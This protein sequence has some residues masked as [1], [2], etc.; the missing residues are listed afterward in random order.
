MIVMREFENNN[1][2]MMI[3]GKSTVEIA[4]EFGTPVYIT[5]EARLRGN[6]R[7]IY[8]AF[9]K[10]MN[11]EV[12]YAC[13]ANS[14]LTILEILKQE[15]SGI[16]TTSVGEIMSCIKTGFDPNKITYAGVNVGN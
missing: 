13:K 4:N 12:H 2:I 11:T 8:S 9:S 6:Y 16:S 15:G 1:G 5:D 14:N 7:K 3:G 10:Y